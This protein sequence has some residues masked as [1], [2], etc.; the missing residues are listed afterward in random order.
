MARP[1]Y[2]NRQFFIKK[3]FQRKFILLYSL[4]A[5]VII[6]VA[7]YFLYLQINTTVEKHLYSTHIKINRVG[8]FLVDLLFTANFYTI[9][10]IVTVV[11]V[12]S[13]V[14]FRGINHNFSRME[15]TLS[16]LSVGNYAVPY[17]AGGSFTEIGNLASLIEQA[18]TANQS[19][20]EQIKSALDMLEESVAQGDPTLLKEGK[21][22]LDK[23][24]NE[25]T[26]S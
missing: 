13:L 3:K 15:E 17:A 23:I 22:Q 20:S 8:D 4:S 21:G 16:A 26:L 14:L 9:F 18:R 25:I 6:G 12:V 11:L 10:A 24:L 7:T 19:R 2:F 5:S 1:S